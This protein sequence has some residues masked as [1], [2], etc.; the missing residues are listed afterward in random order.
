MDIVTHDSSLATFF[1]SVMDGEITHPMITLHLSSDAFHN[2][3]N[4]STH[5]IYG[6]AS[7]RSS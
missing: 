1:Q 7:G 2:V 4:D 6:S 5:A 3:D